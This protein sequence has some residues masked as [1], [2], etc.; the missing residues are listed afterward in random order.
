MPNSPTDPVPSAGLS[1]REVTYRQHDNDGKYLF[2]TRT[3]LGCPRKRVATFEQHMFD[4]NRY[5][6]SSK[7]RYKCAD[8]TE[9]TLYSESLRLRH[10]MSETEL[11]DGPC[12]SHFTRFAV[13]AVKVLMTERMEAGAKKGEHSET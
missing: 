2:T 1:K 13:G 6:L 5:E 7:F 12:A 3:I 9:Q 4:V 11:A 8:V 10:M